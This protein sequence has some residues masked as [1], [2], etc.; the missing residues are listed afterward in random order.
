VIC[1][2]CH[3]FRL[4]YSK[5]LDPACSSL[6]T[7]IDQLDRKIKHLVL[8]RITQDTSAIANPLIKLQ[9]QGLLSHMFETGASASAVTGTSS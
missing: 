4:I 8:D 6:Y 9:L 7:D 5:F 2:L 1:S 3:T